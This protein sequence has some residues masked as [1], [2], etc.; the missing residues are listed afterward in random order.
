MKQVCKRIALVALLIILPLTFVCTTQNRVDHN[1]LRIEGFYQEEKN[2]IDVV[3]FGASEVFTGYAPGYAYEQ[4]GYTSYPYAI[5]ANY[6]GLFINQIEEVLTRQKP[7]CILIETSG[8]ANPINEED[9]ATALATLRK[10]TDVMPLSLN[11]IRTISQNV[12][13]DKLSYYFPFIL[14]HGDLSNLK[15]SLVRF[16]QRNRGCTYLKGITSTNQQ[17]PCS[18]IMD[19]SDDNECTAMSEHDTQIFLDLL[20]YCKT[21]DCKVIFVRF[22]HRITVES[23]YGRFKVQNQIETLARQNGFDFIH[24]D[25]KFQD[26]DLS[27]NED[28]YGDSHLNVNGQIKL[29]TYIGTLLQQQYQ[30]GPSDLSATCK[31]KWEKSAQ[32]TDLFFQFYRLHENDGTVAWWYENPNLLASLDALR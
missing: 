27:P 22:P 15:G 4:F 31:E 18:G 10:W 32:Y 17:S 25:K 1:T 6:T 24:L 2:T 12:N 3:L 21:L 26:L 30:I 14:Y 5:D 9:S 8:Y 11:K 23:G 20:E 16:S 7:K 28:F 19:V 29:T 13:S